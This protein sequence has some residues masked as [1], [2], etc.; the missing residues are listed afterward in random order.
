MDML[1]VRDNAIWSQ[2]TACCLQWHKFMVFDAIIVKMNTYV[3]SMAD[4][5]H[6]VTLMFSLQL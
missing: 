1:F 4:V 2:A 3:V 5:V 6:G